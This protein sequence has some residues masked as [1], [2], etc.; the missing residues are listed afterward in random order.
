MPELELEPLLEHQQ[1][2][3]ELGPATCVSLA[4]SLHSRG[5]SVLE[6]ASLILGPAVLAWP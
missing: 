2:E 3:L 4:L 6:L 1:P 5:A